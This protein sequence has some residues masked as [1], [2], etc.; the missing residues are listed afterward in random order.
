MPTQHR[1]RPRTQDRSTASTGEALRSIFNRNFNVVACINLLVMTAYYLMFVTSTA[2]AR[3]TYGASLS[4][5][6]LT[7]GIMV[8]GC[9]IG[10]FLTGNL[11]S[12]CGCRA[13]LFAGLLLYSASI[14]AFFW[15]PNLALLFVQRLCMGMGVG[16]MGTAT[17][18]IVAYVV[19]HQHHGLGISLFSMST[20][21]A[22]ALGPFLGILISQYFSYTV[23]AQTC[24]GIGLA[25]IA[26]FFGLHD[27]PEMRHRHRP[28]LELNSY[29]DPRVVRFSL[30]ALITCLSY[31]CIQ[32]FMTSYAAERGLT[33]AAS[34]FFLLYAL[35]ALVTR[36]LTGRLFDLRGE[37]IIFYPAL[38]LTALSLTMMAH[39][40]SS[41]V[42]LAAGL[43][44][45]ILISQYFSYTVLAQTCLGIGLACIAI[46]FGLHDLPEM[47]HRH[48]PFLE[49]NSYIDPRVVRFSLVAL[50]T[51]L[52]YGCI[53]AFM[54][55]YAAERGLTG[56]A[57]LF[58]LL[59]ALAALVTRPLTG[60][61]FDLRGE[62]IIFYPALLLTALSLTMMA[63]ANSS[64][65]LLAAGLIL[66]MG[67]GNFQSAGQA[68]SLSLVSKSRFA[69]ATTTFFIFFDL[70]IGLGPYL[71]GFMI[72]AAGYDGMYQTLAF[73]VLGAVALYYVLHGRRVAAA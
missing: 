34:L 17:G 61:L 50:I 45:G 57:S 70:G 18:T 58:F 36:P 48:R 55:S 49:L 31:G 14:A 13:I 41:W 53:Q 44:L 71:F 3:A 24:L 39:A 37:N 46:F 32:A 51:C 30:V 15:V 38:L 5:A 73:V 29:I 52:S 63:H 26:I 67:F 28:F 43:I 10:R 65:V 35:A 22:L 4:S 64:W 69:Q 16:I 42:L 40:N 1:S 7:A 12:L 19:P 68:V 2:Y 21:F 20:A 23:L 60:R 8:I 62:N 66:G 56:A 47:R 27:L 54:T 59:Y 6:G 25:C 72:P 11:L 33:G 9:L